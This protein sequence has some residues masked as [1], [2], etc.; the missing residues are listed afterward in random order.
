VAGHCVGRA[1]GYPRRDI[2]SS[3]SAEAFEAWD[4]DKTGDWTSAH[5]DMSEELAR[6]HR[7][8]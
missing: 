1:V 4:R 5:D 2:W 8:Y 3:A 6:K 7:V